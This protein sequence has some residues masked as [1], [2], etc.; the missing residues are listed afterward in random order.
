VFMYLRGV[1]QRPEL[2]EASLSCST[3]RKVR[4]DGFNV[5]YLC[6]YRGFASGGSGC[7]AYQTA[8]A[9]NQSDGG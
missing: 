4:Y 5:G 9:T 8:L 2:R 6:C 7:I 1:I 3:I